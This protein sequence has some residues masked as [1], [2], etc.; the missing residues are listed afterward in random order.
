[1]K[2]RDF[3]A[4]DIDVDVY[5]NVCEEL[6]IAFC[7]SLKLTDAG[8]RYFAEVLDMD[9]DYKDGAEYAILDVDGK[10]WHH[11]LRIAREFFESAA[12]YCPVSDYERWFKN[13]GV[14]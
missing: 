11:N 1:M 13:D 12:G 9:I 2:V 14:S 7:G 4:K 3:I 8:E 10:A 6:S 5:D